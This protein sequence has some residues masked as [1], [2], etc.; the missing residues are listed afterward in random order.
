M[1]LTPYQWNLLDRLSR[2]VEIFWYRAGARHTGSYRLRRVATREVIAYDSVP[3]GAQSNLLAE[4]AIERY[5]LGGDSWRI[6]ARGLQALADRRDRHHAAARKAAA[7]ASD[8]AV[9][10]PRHESAGAR[11]LTPAA[12]IQTAPNRARDKSVPSRPSG[13]AGETG[14]HT[15]RSEEAPR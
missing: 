2:G 8:H 4:K 6:T 14:N 13:T 7:A 3:Q 9:A 10:S 5:G 12:A 15:S 11:E 1:K